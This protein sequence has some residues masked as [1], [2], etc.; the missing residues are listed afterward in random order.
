MPA[1]MRRMQFFDVRKI[2]V[3]GARYREP[4]A[5]I[6]ALELP[7]T[8]SVYDDLDALE[9]RLRRLGGIEE[10]TVGRR[11]PGTL[12]IRIRETE[13]VALAQSRTG[14]V[15]VDRGGHP[16]PYDLAVA[17]VDV[18]LVGRAEPRL[19]EALAEIRTASAGLYASASAAWIRGG[20]EVVLDVGEGLV[21][22]DAPVDEAVLDAIGAVQRDLA[23]HAID[24]A[25][26]D[27]RF[28]GWIVVRQ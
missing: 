4:S 17:P 10:A 15:A 14:L 2:E 23:Q 21:R 3:T 25:E 19:I 9:D 20:R 8:P 26:V 16:L 18:P 24:W 11:L 6:A 5:I 7:D 22:L 27:G 13:P 1:I 12:E 28:K